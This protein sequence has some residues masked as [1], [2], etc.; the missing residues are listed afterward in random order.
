M[1]PPVPYQVKEEAASLRLSM[2]GIQTDA[3]DIC[4]MLAQHDG[5]IE[6]RLELRKLAEPRRPL[7]S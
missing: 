6:P 7:E 4:G 1:R 3:H 5:W 2:T